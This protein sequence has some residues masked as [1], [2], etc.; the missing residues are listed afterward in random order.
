MTLTMKRRF[1]H[2]NHYSLWIYFTIGILF[3][4]SLIAI[5]RFIPLT[6]ALTFWLVALGALAAGSVIAGLPYASPALVFEMSV[7]ILT[8][9]VFKGK[10]YGNGAFCF[11]PLVAAVLISVSYSVMP[12][13]SPIVATLLTAGWFILAGGVFRT[14]GTMQWF[15]GAV[16]AIMLITFAASII[17]RPRK[18]PRHIDVLLCSY[19]SNTAHYTGLFSEAAFKAGAQVTVHRFHHYRDFVTRYEGDAFVIAFPVIGWKPP[20]PMLAYIIFNLPGGGGKPA[21]ILYTAAGGP[22]NAGMFVWLLLTLKGYRVAGR[23]WSVYPLNLATIRLGSQTFW[24]RLDAL[25]PLSRDVCE[26]ADAGRRFVE[27]KPAG[28]P[29]IFWPFFLWIAGTIVD[30]PILNRIY[31]NHAFKK[32]CNAC[33]IC[34]SYCPA[35]R[36]R[37][38]NRRPRP[39]GTC[40]LCFGCVNICPTNAM[41]IWF[42]TE[43]G[44]PYQPK[45]PSLIVKKKVSNVSVENK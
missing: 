20:W 17:L 7:L 35:E 23:S 28:L 2:Q 24:Q 16:T 14:P 39:K 6:N 22:E 29:I 38:V 25:L 12:V 37:M 36:L 4:V 34:V 5:L 40:T 19:S 9:L 21:Y 42:L 31:R 8:W 10:G 13:L 18:I 32:R 33:G 43:Y 3:A 27:G 26:V 11:L 44:R 41:Q 1:H 30:N 15:F 45:W